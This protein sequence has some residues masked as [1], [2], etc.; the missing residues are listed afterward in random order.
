MRYLKLLKVFT[1]LIIT[2][3]L[4]A[5]CSSGRQVS[6]IDTKE[7]VDLSGRWNDTDARLVAEEMVSDVLTRP[8]L[9]EYLTT[10]GKKPVVIVGKIRNKSSEHIAVDVFANDIERELLNSGRVT[11]VASQ[12]AREEVREERKDQQDFASAETFKKFYREI[13]ADFLM[14]GVINSVQD[15]YEGEQVTYYQ[16]DLELINI[17]DNTKAWIGTK[18]IKKYIGQDSY[19]L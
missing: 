14:T 10:E 4:A 15:T 16:V 9:T 6:R 11:F 18:K 17:E 1:V 3:L 8:W 19:K 12:D 2:A 7:I 13:G 5:G